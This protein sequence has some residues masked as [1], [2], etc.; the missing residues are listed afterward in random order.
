MS[1]R[2]TARCS[3]CAFDRTADSSLARASS[4]AVSLC[5]RVCARSYSEADSTICELLPSSCIELLLFGSSPR[6]SA[7]V[8]REDICFA[9]ESTSCKPRAMCGP[10]TSASSTFCPM[11]ADR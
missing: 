9:R 7:W 6:T 11:L 10:W 5:P 4:P 8:S 1:K 2:F 3:S